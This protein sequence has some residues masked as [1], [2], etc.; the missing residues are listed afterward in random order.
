MTPRVTLAIAVRV[1]TQLRRDHRTLA[2]LLVLPCLLQ[3]LLW[4]I[5]DSTPLVFDRIGP[6]LLAIFPFFVMFLVT[7]ITTLRE[8]SSGTLE[9]LFTLP[10]GRLDFLCGYALAFG[11]VAAVQAAL[12][13]GVAAGL[14]DLDVDG[15]VVLL[16]VVGVADAVLGTALGL[17]VS[18]FARTEFQAVQFLP[19]VV[20]PQ[21]LLCGLIL[22]RDHLPPVLEAIAGVLPLTYA[23]DAMEQLATTSS[24]GQVWRDVGIVVAFAIA[25]LALGAVTLRRR[26]D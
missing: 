17:F 12:A 13:S 2:M 20:V 24:T 18:A 22:P 5:F 26:T 3:V 9:R 11:A 21:I 14:L 4:W 16:I 8:R 25:A 23:V 19:A 7:S 1:L 10:M 15:P 6:A